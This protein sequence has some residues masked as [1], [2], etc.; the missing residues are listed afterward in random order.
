[1]NL[2]IVI[3]EHNV[4]YVKEG[5]ENLDK[6]RFLQIEYKTEAKYGFGCGYWRVCD[7]HS[8]P[9][10]LTNKGFDEDIY[11]KMRKRCFED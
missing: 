2:L 9:C 3:V 8:C 11:E 10:A 7:D 6:E 1:M 5:D 4:I